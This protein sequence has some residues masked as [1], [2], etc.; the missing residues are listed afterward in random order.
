M[1]LLLDRCAA[2]AGCDL[3]SKRG[4]L[5]SHPVHREGPKGEQVLRSIPQHSRS[6]IYFSIPFLSLPFFKTL[7]NVVQVVCFLCT[8]VLH[9]EWNV[10]EISSIINKNHYAS[11]YIF[12]FF[13]L[14]VTGECYRTLGRVSDAQ[15]QFQIAVAL[16]P[17]YLAP[18]FNLGLT[19]QQT[20]QWERAIQQYRCLLLITLSSQSVP[21]SSIPTSPYFSFLLSLTLPFIGMNAG[22]SPRPR[23]MRK[24]WGRQMW[25]L[26]CLIELEWKV[27]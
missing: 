9:L 1:F 20:D 23:R 5:F 27:R 17:N 2:H 6:A 15:Q 25:G 21:H 4:P 26:L 16:N 8:I 22:L 14:F 3:L 10:S 13:F 12:Y 18:V 24:D 7:T 19:Y 11:A